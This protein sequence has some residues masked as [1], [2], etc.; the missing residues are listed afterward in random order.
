MRADADGCHAEP[1]N[2]SSAQACCPVELS[3][4]A[5]AVFTANMKNDRFASGPA[6]SRSRARSTSGKRLSNTS[7]TRTQSLR[8]GPPLPRRATPWRG[9]RRHRRCADGRSAE[10]TKAD[11][12]RDARCARPSKR[13]PFAVRL[14]TQLIQ[15]PI[16]W[17]AAAYRICQS[18]LLWF[19]GSRPH[20]AKGQPPR[21]SGSPS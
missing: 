1:C 8:R 12:R 9:R 15:L 14:L 10:A 2:R 11:G 19:S 6:R 17:N 5:P 4:E 16:D 7:F 21:R 18:R 3:V 20:Q 13:S